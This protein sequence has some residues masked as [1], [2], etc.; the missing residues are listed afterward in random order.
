MAMNLGPSPEFMKKF[1]KSN[2][3]DKK[4][5]GGNRGGGKKSRLMEAMKKKK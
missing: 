4:M 1:G 3:K 5:S 2:P